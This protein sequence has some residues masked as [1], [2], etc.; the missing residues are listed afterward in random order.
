[1][2]RLRMILACAAAGAV[3]ALGAAGPTD[4]AGRIEG[5]V[6]NQLNDGYAGLRVFANLEGD[7]GHYATIT[8][9]DGSFAF[10]VPVG[11]YALASERP[12]GAIPGYV[13]VVDAVEGGVEQVQVRIDS[14]YAIPAGDQ[15]WGR[16]SRVVG[17]SFTANGRSIVGASVRGE[18]PAPLRLRI[19]VGGPN[20]AVISPLLAAETDETG[21]E[22][23][24]TWRPGSVRTSP[25]K[26]YYLEALM[27]DRQPW[28][29]YVSVRGDCYRNGSV[30]FDGRA[31]PHHDLSARVF[32]DSAQYP[33]A[34]LQWSPGDRGA[35]G[36]EIGQV[37]VATG[38]C[39]L[40]AACYAQAE[41]TEKPLVLVYA[42]LEDGPNG[43]QVGP[44]KTCEAAPGTEHAVAWL[45][46]EVSLDPGRR[47]Y[48]R[49]RSAPDERIFCHLT[50]NDYSFGHAVIDGKSEWGR[51][52]AGWM[53]QWHP[54]K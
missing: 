19:K 9:E 23:S 5:R 25:G 41:E 43:R 54:T 38:D 11:T 47:Y 14:A 37:F 15:L 30:H 45:P 26:T 7:I 21:T 22:H 18:S 42:V 4:G 44:S 1:M 24:V 13:A 27:A 16:S 40:A 28:S 53:L 17:Q 12:A 39:L 10:E 31:D 52:L 6:R 8:G 50:E 46:G 3:A 51:D 32:C 48:L 33:A 35:W 2:A 36:D 20:G 29:C 49:I 34:Y